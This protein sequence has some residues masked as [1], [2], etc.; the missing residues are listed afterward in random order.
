VQDQM[1]I[2]MHT[3][4]YDIQVREHMMMMYMYVHQIM[5]VS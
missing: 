1:P 2:T 3:F 4:L 5:I